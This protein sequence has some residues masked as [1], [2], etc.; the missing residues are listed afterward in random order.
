VAGLNFAGVY[1]DVPDVSVGG[2]VSN[3]DASKIVL[4]QLGPTV[5]G[6]FDT[7]AGAKNS[8]ATEVWFSA[9]PKPK[10]CCVGTVVN[11]PIVEVGRVGECCRPIYFREGGAIE[12]STSSDG[13]GVVPFFSSAILGGAV[14]TGRLR[15]AVDRANSPPWSH[16]MTPPERR[17]YI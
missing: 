5:T 6:A 15:I 16:R 7:D 1:I 3:E 14:R 8:E 12:Q 17:P 13:Q 2:S 10:R 9:V 11:S 4:V